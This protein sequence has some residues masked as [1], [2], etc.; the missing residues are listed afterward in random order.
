MG[1]WGPGFPAVRFWS[2]VSASDPGGPWGVAPA[3]WFWCL[4]SAS[5][6]FCPRGV[7]AGVGGV[8]AVQVAKDVASRPPSARLGR[9]APGSGPGIPRGVLLV[10]I[11]WES[12]TAVLRSFAA[13]SDSFGHRSAFVISAAAFHFCEAGSP[14]VRSGYRGQCLGSRIRCARGM[15]IICFSVASLTFGGWSASMSGW[16]RPLAPGDV[17]PVRHDRAVLA[18]PVSDPLEAV[19]VARASAVDVQGVTVSAPLLEPA[20]SLCCAG[21]S[22]SHAGLGVGERGEEMLALPAHVGAEF[23]GQMG[24]P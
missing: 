23:A 17:E 2:L 12:P 7:I 6:P 14:M 13:A 16:V 22:A 8:V 15:H 4:L 19:S 11:L 9:V 3:P 1:P 20:L 18:F 21:A 24:G 5:D 10:R